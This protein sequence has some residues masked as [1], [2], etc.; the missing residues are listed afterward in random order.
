MDN[1]LVPPA[2]PDDQKITPVL[3]LVVMDNSLVPPVVELGDSRRYV[4][5][6]L[7]VMD[8]SLVLTK[9]DAYRTDITGS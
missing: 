7:V 9:R 2:V 4:V 8:N 5:L 1:S 3:I 6:I